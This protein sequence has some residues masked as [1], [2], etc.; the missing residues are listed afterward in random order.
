MIEFRKRIEWALCISFLAPHSLWA[1]SSDGKDALIAISS[2]KELASM[3]KDTYTI[4]FNN[5][6]ML[7]FL[8]F[9]S[10]LTNLNF[11]FQEADVQFTVSLISEEPVSAKN[12]MA[13]L[14]QVLRIHDLI[15][16]EQDGNVIITRSN[17]V[18]Q[19]SPIVSDDLA[20]AVSPNTLLVTR[21]FRIK[22]ANANTIA[23]IIRPMMSETA[24]IEVSNETRQLIVTDIVTNVE[25]IR[26]STHEY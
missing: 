1:F 21:V 14:A 11:I 18:N 15:L 23:G 13:V 7:E 20:E 4:N 19:I 25:Q 2:N 24:M 10:K 22:N 3:Q 6:S 8:R 17:K 16:L 5:I 26:C 12:V 9:C